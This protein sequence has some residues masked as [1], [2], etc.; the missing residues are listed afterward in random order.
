[1]TKK[2][3]F[4]EV[5]LT[6]DVYRSTPFQYDLTATPSIRTETFGHSH[7]FGRQWNGLIGNQ[8]PRPEPNAARSAIPPKSD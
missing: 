5:V 6:P 4:E 8:S 7:L 3:F 2:A 1:M